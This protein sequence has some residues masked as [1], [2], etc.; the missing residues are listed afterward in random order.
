MSRSESMSTEKI[1]V[2]YVQSGG[3]KLPDPMFMTHII[4]AFGEFNQSNDGVVIPSP[5]KLKS[6]VDL[7]KINPNLKIILGI[8]GSKR[9]G[10]SEMSR[11]ENMRRT[12]INS[13]DSILQLFTLDGIDLD[14]EFP[15]TTAGGHTASPADD[16]NYVL[17]VK[18]LREKLGSKKH[19]SIYSN[20]SARWIRFEEM[21][22]SLNYINVSG[23]NLRIKEGHQSNLYSSD[24]CGNWSVDKS[25]AR[26]ISKGVP[27]EKIL[28]GIPF[29][30][31]G[32]DPF[33]S[34]IEDYKIDRYKGNLQL[35]WDDEA[36][37]PYYTDDHGSIILGFDDTE[38]VHVKCQYSKDKNLGGIF[39]WNYDAD[40]FDHSL[41]KTIK[42]N[43]LGD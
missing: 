38:S 18:E 4:Y 32:R 8:G 35:K 29:F 31:R 24:I 21:V 33:P 11:D 2:A 6:L 7:K 26:H 12:F 19:I 28:L 25:I 5:D 22:P 3:T 30:G 16:K 27:S 1:I 9:E 10:F 13:C 41:A 23:Y 42:E 20:N 37:V 43:L 15:T 39:Y 17:L 34:F 36:K 40:F 14:W